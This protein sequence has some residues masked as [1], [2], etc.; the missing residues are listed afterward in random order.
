[1]TAEVTALGDEQNAIV[2]KQNRLLAAVALYQDLGGGFEAGDLPGAGKI[3]A[4]VPVL[5]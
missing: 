2:L 5:P 3:L 4:G 1:V